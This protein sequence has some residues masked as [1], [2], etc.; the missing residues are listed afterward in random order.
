MSA[1]VLSNRIEP[2]VLV[3]SSGWVQMLRRSGDPAIRAKVLDIFE[4]GRAAWCELIRVELWRGAGSDDDRTI[5][6]QFEIEL[7]SLELSA[8]VWTLSCE[9]A[10]QCRRKGR[11]IPTTDLI[12]YACAKVHRVELIHRDNHF[13]VLASLHG[14]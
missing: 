8:A 6:R 5:L 13:D 7:P 9:L 3:D 10:Q 1:A 4:D 14:S 11:P 12:I 2:I